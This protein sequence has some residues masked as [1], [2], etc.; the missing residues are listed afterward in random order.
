[1]TA[2][3]VRWHRATLNVVAFQ[4]GWFACVLG[5]GVIG[6][7]AA[8]AILIWHLRVMARPGE[9]RWLVGFAV[10][11]FAVEGGLALAGG[12]RFAPDTL[13]VGPLALWLWWLWPLFATLL[14]HSLNWLWYRPWLA[15]LGGAVSAP[16]S[17]VGGATL[18]GVEL[19]P[20]LLPVQATFWALLCRALCLRLSPPR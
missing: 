15:A 17:Y 18:A 14:M 1:M 16:L 3:P 4:L 20:W 10:L 5:G 2:P 8:G 11:G 7:A 6:T 12:Y 13:S 19:A 9:W